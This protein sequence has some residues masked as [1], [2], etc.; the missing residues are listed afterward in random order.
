[1]NSR[2]RSVL[3]RITV[4]VAVFLYVAYV[5]NQYVLSGR[6]PRFDFAVITAFVAVYF[7]WTILSETLLYRDP[8]VFVVE[9]D[10]RWSYAYLQLFSMIALLY[11]AIDFLS[12]H[13]TRMYIL[14]PGIIYT[15]FILF[16]ISCFIRW[17]GFAAIGKF[18]NP[19]IAV[20]EEHLLIT[21]GAY[22]IIRHPLYLGVF[23]SLI[24]IA[25]IL[26]S[27]GALLITLLATL[28]ALIYRINLEE[29]FMVKHFGDQ[30]REYMKKTRKLIPG[31]W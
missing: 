1:M 28:P 16:F 5:A 12:L 2:Q 30:Y 18:F 14:E 11:A 15:G 27:W 4:A 9:D 22:R 23:V 29:A 31:L 8:D 6:L 25:M 7:V 17:R 3:I 24:A 10:D 13:K 21:G 26:S 20:Y 19:R